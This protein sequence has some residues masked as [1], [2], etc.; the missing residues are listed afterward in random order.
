MPGERKTLAKDFQRR[1]IADSGV[2]GANAGERHLTRRVEE[3]AAE[4]QLLRGS[5]LPRIF[6][7]FPAKIDDGRRGGFHAIDYSVRSFGPYFTAVAST[8]RAS[9]SSQ[10]RSPSLLMSIHS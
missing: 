2:F 4:H 3:I 9:L 6:N 7:L 8:F 1:V 5:E 10:I